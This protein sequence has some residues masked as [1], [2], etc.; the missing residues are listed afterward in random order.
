MRSKIQNIKI[1]LSCTRKSLGRS[2][3]LL[4]KKVESCSENGMRITARGFILFT[5]M[6]PYNID[7]P[8]NRD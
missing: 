5:I 7:S 2:V 3:G 4:N 8:L 6:Y 1:I